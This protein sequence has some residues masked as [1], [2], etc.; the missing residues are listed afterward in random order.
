MAESKGSDDRG[1]S[2]LSQRRQE[3]E[4][5]GNSGKLLLLEVNKITSVSNPVS[6]L[7][8]LWPSWS[9]KHKDLENEKYFPVIK[10]ENKSRAVRGTKKV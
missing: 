2:S 9:S 8:F 1:T 7:T 6:P 4:V 5:W 10:K 3:H